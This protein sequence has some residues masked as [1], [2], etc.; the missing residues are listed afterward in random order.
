M[1]I[2]QPTTGR[3]RHFCSDRCRKAWGAAN[4][5]RIDPLVRQVIRTGETASKL[6][7]AHMMGD[8]YLTRRHT[9]EVRATVLALLDL[10]YQAHVFA[11]DAELLRFIETLR[12]L[13]DDPR[14]GDT[15]L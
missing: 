10:L 2:K 9:Q 7:H 8:I 4:S 6:T 14:P 1:A 5:K 11:G 15:D 12:D 3:F 13:W